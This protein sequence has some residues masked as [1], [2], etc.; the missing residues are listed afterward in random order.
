MRVLITGVNGYIGSQLASYLAA[1]KIYDVVGT[2]RI[3][4]PTISSE[5]TI[6]E[7][8]AIS[9]CTDWTPALNDVDVI[10]HLAARAHVLDD[11]A[12]RPLDRFRSVNVE[13]SLNLAS[14]AIAHGVK[15][16]IFISSI[17][18]NGPAT[19]G[20]AF[21]E[22]DIPSPKAA[23]A[24]S[25]LEAERAL[26][27]VFSN[28]GIE[29]VIIRP[30]L[31]YDATAPGNFKRLLRLVRF[32]VP[33]PLGCATAKRSFIALP[34]LISFIAM[35]IEH[36]KAANDLFLISDGEDVS[37]SRLCR[38]LAEGMGHRSYLIPVPSFIVGL[39]ARLVGKQEIHDQ[40]FS[41]LIIDSSKARITLG[42]KPESTLNEAV[43][44]T[45]RT[46]KNLA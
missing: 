15:R 26:R 21:L 31:V 12:E 42:W 2:V 36:P 30:P 10:I 20:R 4:A 14:Q 11:E 43:G 34:N 9:A 35:C 33:L 25:K 17:G 38:M 32:R 39:A 24:V 23:Y 28:T 40:L 19:H 6:Y 41:A 22:T 46:Y 5:L 16:F 44:M 8:G 45:G 13:G 18:V 3:M 29:L 27:D 1:K 37:V 7:T